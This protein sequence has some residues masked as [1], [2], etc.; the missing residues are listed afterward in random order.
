MHRFAAVLAVAF[1]LLCPLEAIAEESGRQSCTLD[2]AM[3]RIL[4]AKQNAGKEKT[5]WQGF[6]KSPLLKTKHEG[7][8]VLTQN[9]KGEWTLIAMFPG[10][11][12]CLI[13]SGGGAT[14]NRRPHETME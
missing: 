5:I 11:P 4:T 2:A 10:R 13:A 12:A 3:V 14:V 1:P 9:K 8:W 6:A 7:W